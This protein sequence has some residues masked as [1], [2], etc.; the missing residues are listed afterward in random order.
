MQR[1][2]QFVFIVYR[3]EGYW[4]ILKLCCR[5]FAFTSF[6]AFLKNK[7]RY[8]TSVSII[9]EERY[10]TVGIIHWLVRFHCRVAFTSRDFGKYMSC[11]HCV[12]SVQI[13]S[14]FWFVFSRTFSE[15]G[16]ITTRKDSVFG[17]FSHSE[18]LIN[19]VV[20]SWIFKLTL[21]L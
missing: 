4:K 20:I 2:I 6:K 14:F 3:I 12:K 15:Y 21:P 19:P 17:H 1:F 5:S 13:R 7:K 9:L 11:N 10:I 18:L 8:G 16:K